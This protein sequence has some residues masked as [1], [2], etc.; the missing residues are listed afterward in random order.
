MTICAQFSEGR[1]LAIQQAIT[2]LRVC[3]HCHH[4]Q[5]TNPE[6]PPL[7]IL[8]H[9]PVVTVNGLPAAPPTDPAVLATLAKQ[10]GN[11]DGCGDSPLP[12]I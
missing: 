7:A 6:W 10:N 8:P 11:C 3:Y 2:D 9:V 1:C 5:R 12:G 4:P